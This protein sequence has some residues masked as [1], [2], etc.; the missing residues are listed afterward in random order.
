MLLQKI[1]ITNF[2]QYK[3]TTEIAFST[4]KKKNVTVIMGENGTGKTTLAQAF[5]WVLYGETEFKVKEL[6]NREL[7]DKMYPGDEQQVK[8]ELV[9]Q[10]DVG[11]YYHVVRRQKYICKQK[12][13]DKGELLFTVRYKDENGQLQSMVP[14]FYF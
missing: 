10:D 2:R 9:V 11:K 14:V 6:L 3:G 7:R 8:V 12:R 1:S 13:V 4:D 5:M